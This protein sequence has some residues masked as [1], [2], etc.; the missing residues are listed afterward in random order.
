[1]IKFYRFGTVLIFLCLSVGIFAQDT[2]SQK[3]LSDMKQSTIDSDYIALIEANID[4]ISIDQL[5]AIEA[6]LIDSTV[7]ADRHWF[8][9]TEYG[10]WDEYNFF[11]PSGDV[12]LT[13]LARRD[14]FLDPARQLNNRV[15]T[16][17]S[18]QALAA[19]VFSQTYVEEKWDHTVPWD[20]EP[21]RVYNWVQ[22]E[23]LDQP[24]FV[25]FVYGDYLY[26]ERVR[27]WY[28][29]YYPDLLASFRDA[30]FSD[31]D[32]IDAALIYMHAPN[33]NAPRLAGY[34]YPIGNQLYLQTAET[35]LWYSDYSSVAE[36]RYGQLSEADLDTEIPLPLNST[37]ILDAIPSDDWNFS[38]IDGLYGLLYAPFANALRKELT[39]PELASFW[40]VMR[41]VH[42]AARQREGGGSAQRPGDNQP[43]IMALRYHERSSMPVGRKTEDVSAFSIITT[44]YSD[45]I[46][47]DFTNWNN[48][49]QSLIVA[50]E[51]DIRSDGIHRQLSERN[52]AILVVE[53]MGSET[54]YPNATHVSGS[55][56]LGFN[57]S[58]QYENTASDFL[59][60]TLEEAYF[61]I[62]ALATEYKDYGIESS[63][64]SLC[65]SP[66][67]RIG[68]D[69]YIA[70]HAISDTVAINY[71]A[72]CN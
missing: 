10:S 23:L 27:Y 34:S 59:P 50:P 28:A 31:G 64:Y 65:H 36:Q 19:L 38:E 3:I 63:R 13:N 44:V 25:K 46:L 21:N 60:Y 26:Q 70:H 57:L 15:I 33:A 55:R 41:F 54:V 61:L 69:K 47:L 48:S 51:D 29:T 30:D 18:D 37:Q 7:I 24:L 12:L 53:H 32:D 6:F 45:S 43:P 39:H 20:G 35:L 40:N 49:T 5:I 16:N 9:V 8:D 42:A 2:S 71:D 1:M 68:Y 14:L 58:T 4:N 72:F 62:S 56:G 17:M 66:L 22:P 67:L 11:R 52:K